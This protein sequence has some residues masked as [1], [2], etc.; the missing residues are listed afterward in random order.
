MSRRAKKKSAYRRIRRPRRRNPV[1]RATLADFNKA[2]MESAN[3]LLCLIDNTCKGEKFEGYEPRFAG[4]IPWDPRSGLKFYAWE[5]KLKH[6]DGSFWDWIIVDP[7]LKKPAVGI[8]TLWK[9]KNGELETGS[10]VMARDYRR[11][12]I[13]TGVLPLL[14][15]LAGVPIW[16]DRS[17]TAGAERVWKKFKKQGRAEY[18]R[19]QD[20]WKMAN[21][22]RR[23]R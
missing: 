20:R 10:A 12:G 3:E 2:H 17:R 21:P 8:G 6:S 7:R 23:A 11:K 1:A 22:K 4:D 9:N 16:S 19:S 14:R 18:F 5:K 15:E 13:Y